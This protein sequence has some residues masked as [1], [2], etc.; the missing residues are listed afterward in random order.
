MTT[1]EYH[2]DRWLRY[3]ELTAW[4]QGLAADHPDLVTVESYGTQPRGP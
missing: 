4:L 2:F 3:E 1:P